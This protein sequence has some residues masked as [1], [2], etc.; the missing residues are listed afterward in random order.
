MG[1]NGFLEF[2]R[3]EVSVCRAR[4]FQSVGNSTHQF[5]N[6]FFSPTEMSTGMTFSFPSSLLSPS[7]PSISVPEAFFFKARN[8]KYRTIKTHPHIPIMKPRLAGK[9]FLYFGAS[10]TGYKNC[11][12]IVVSAAPHEFIIAIVRARSWES[13]EQ[14]ML[15]QDM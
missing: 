10:V 12:M 13:R 6:H 15:A 1:R 4:N 14:R 9:P 3:Y 2:G 8:S 11:W 7:T 5:I